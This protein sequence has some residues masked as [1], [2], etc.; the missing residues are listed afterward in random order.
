[1]NFNLVGVQCE[2]VLYRL[3]YL[4][5]LRSIS[6]ST[7]LKS[8]STI[9]VP[10]IPLSSVSNVSHLSPKACRCSTINWPIREKDSGGG[11]GR[12]KSGEW[13]WNDKEGSLTWTA[14]THSWMPEDANRLSI[15]IINTCWIF[16][17]HSTCVNISNGN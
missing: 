1:M 11:G 16:N 10:I 4:L 5:A 12:S 3:F 9:W 8:Q 7:P 13:G 6:L 17:G 15:K 2:R 14:R